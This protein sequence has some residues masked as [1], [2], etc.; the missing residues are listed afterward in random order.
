MYAH[1]F[2][3]TRI[4]GVYAHVFD[5]STRIYGVYAHIFDYSTRSQAFALEKLLDG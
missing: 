4:D 2:D 1:I 5:Y 3:R